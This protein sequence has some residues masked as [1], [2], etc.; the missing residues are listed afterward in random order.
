MKAIDQR[1]FTLW[2]LLMTL[3]VAGILVGIGVPNLMEF[4]RNGVMTAAANQLVTGVLMAR[5]E[6]V[7]RQVPVTLCLSDN[8][9]APAPTCLPNAVAD[10]A[11]RGFIVWADENGNLDANG[12]PNLT[13][14]PDGTGV[15]DAGETILMQSAAPG[16][17]SRTSANC[18]HIGYAP[19][20]FTRRIGALCFQAVR[21]VLFCDDRGR[22]IAA[23]SLSSARIVRI[24]PPGRG[25]VLQQAADVNPLIAAT[26]GTC[27]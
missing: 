8:A 6:A 20:G 13:D 19:S 1:G 14:A 7:K 25:Q 23:G 15:V 10:S 11:T 24:D 26:G 22:R 3:L 5:A 18:G 12:A 27:P 2:E 17:T 4:Q 9:T 21:A 16:G